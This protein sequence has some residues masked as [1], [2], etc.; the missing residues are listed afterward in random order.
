MCG[1]PAVSIFSAAYRTEIKLKQVATEDCYL[2]PELGKHILMSLRAENQIWEDGDPFRSAD[3]NTLTESSFITSELNH[4]K[5]EHQGSD[6]VTR[7]TAEDKCFIL[8]LYHIGILLAEYFREKI[9]QNIF[10][11]MKWHLLKR[12]RKVL[13]KPSHEAASP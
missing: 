4:Y 3:T 10:I 1:N 7:N 6:K 2:C 13:C 8:I 12:G 11:L 5:E 9:W